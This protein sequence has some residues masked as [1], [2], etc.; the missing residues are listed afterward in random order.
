LSFLSRYF[1]TLRYLKPQ[2]V[3]RRVWF[4]VTKPRVDNSPAPAIRDPVG[5][6]HSPARRRASLLDADTF[7]FLNE[8]GALSALG[9]VSAEKADSV[10]KLWR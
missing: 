2:Q 9:W 5:I 4:R 3:Y 7:I 1:Y 6:F 10:S 8:P